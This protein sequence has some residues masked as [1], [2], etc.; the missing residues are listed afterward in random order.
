VE[1]MRKTSVYLR[2]EEARALQAASQRARRS[3]SDLIRQGVR[4]V[5]RA[6]FEGDLD[7]D[8][9]LAPFESGLT[10]PPRETRS[11]ALSMTWEESLVLALLRSGLT[12]E[13]IAE[14]QR[15]SLDQALAVVNRVV[16]MLE[17][18]PDHDSGREWA[19]DGSDPLSFSPA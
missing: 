2:A 4:W 5:S 1:A 16:A 14:H 10:S 8:P 12:L 18:D 15:I 13:Q 6:A 7:W 3:Q 17:S 11:A 9:P 19:D